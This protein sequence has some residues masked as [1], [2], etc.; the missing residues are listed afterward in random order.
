V[1]SAP[2]S[3]RFL[4][5]TTPNVW[6]SYPVPPNRRA[7]VKAIAAVNGTAAQGDVYVQIAGVSF[8]LWSAPGGIGGQFATTSQVA[9]AGETIRGYC[10][11][12]GMGL[13]VSGY[14][15]LDDGLSD[16]GH[17]DVYYEAFYRPEQL[18]GASAS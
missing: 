8:F 16:D 10:Q 14:L 2:Y 4:Q 3:T 12:P 15:L 18:P 11:Q 6:V 5:V 7:I 9:Y 1:A 17:L 13:T